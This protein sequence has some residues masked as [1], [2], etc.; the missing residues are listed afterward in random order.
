MSR[1][2]VRLVSPAC[3]VLRAHATHARLF[4]SSAGAAAPA[5]AAAA[6]AAPK[7]AAADKAAA[8][9]AGGE[10]KASRADKKAAKAAA[11]ATAADADSG[12]AQWD[13]FSVPM[14]V[15]KEV[16]LEILLSLWYSHSLRTI[17]TCGAAIPS[18]GVASAP[19]RTL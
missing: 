13:A 16:L 7:K 9:T 3:A 19:S 1:A 8:P 14:T 12:D 6:S 5:A 18:C 4:A 15:A 11:A 2:L 10:K 17:H